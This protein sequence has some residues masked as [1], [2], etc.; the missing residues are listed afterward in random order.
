[1]TLNTTGNPVLDVIGIV[2]LMGLLALPAAIGVVIWY[3][4]K[5]WFTT[6]IV[7][8]AWVDKKRQKGQV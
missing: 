8:K 7:K 5:V 3:A 2:L 4:I 1:M 6:K